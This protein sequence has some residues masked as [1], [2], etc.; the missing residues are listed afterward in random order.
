L[1]KAKKRQVVEELQERLTRMNSM[2]LAE[3]SGLNVAQTTRIRRE[4]RGIEAEFYVVKNSLLKIA[5]EG[6]RAEAL[7]DTFTGPNALIGVYKDY[8]AAAKLV[9]GFV[10]EMPKLKLKAGFLENRIISAEEILRLATLPSKEVQIANLMGLLKGIPQRLMY[11]FSGNLTR[12]IVTLNAI[13]AQ[14]EQLEGDNI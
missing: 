8:A 2:F 5:S 14:K 7:K 12:L 13:K 9:A 4:L 3:Y 10:K 1:E 11:V 6:T